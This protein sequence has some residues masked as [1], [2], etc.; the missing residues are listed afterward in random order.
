[1][2]QIR[3]N[4][5]CL[6]ADVKTRLERVNK[7]AYNSLK[8]N[9]N[10]SNK[11]A[12]IKYSNSELDE[13][14]NQLKLEQEKATSLAKIQLLNTLLKKAKS[15]SDTAQKMLNHIAELDE[16]TQSF[17]DKDV[18]ALERIAK[19]KQQEQGQGYANN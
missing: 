4:K 12:K 2:G 3:N 1:M 9:Q 19:Q 13:Q 8:F 7:R 16:K 17:L 5:S 18:K 15:S 14:I 6:Q 11:M 10:R